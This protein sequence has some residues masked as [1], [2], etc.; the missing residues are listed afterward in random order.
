[1]SVYCC[2]DLHANYNIWQQIK[3]HLKPNDI[4]YNLG[5]TVDRG[6]AGLEILQ[7]TLEMPNVILLKGNHEDFIDQIGTDLWRSNTN[8]EY[9][10]NLDNLGLWYQNGAKKTIEAF[11]SLTTEEQSKLITK[12]RKLPTHI[13]YTNTEGEILYLTHAGRQPDTAENPDMGEGNIA[14]N[15]YIWDR[16]HLNEKTWR[17]KEN[18]YCVHGHTPICYMR[19]FNPQ[20]IP[21]NNFKIFKYCED[22]KINIDLGVF[23]TH[24]ACLLN[25]D[26]WEEIYFKD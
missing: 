12:I 18:E 3:E 15:N 2:S 16:Y 14:M 10:N 25:L 20:K 5:D 24:I 9:F 11:C 7:E 17:G 1:M 21:Q 4:L 8:E 6:A 23:L 19:Y 13:E 22:H 26:T